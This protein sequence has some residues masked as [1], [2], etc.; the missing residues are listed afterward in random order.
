MKDEWVIHLIM[1]N[2][3][4]QM[5]KVAMELLATRQPKILDMRKRV[6]ELETSIWYTGA[7]G[8]NY[9]KV[10]PVQRDKYCSTCDSRKHEM[11]DC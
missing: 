9:S 8:K 5:T 7:S 3:D 1:E 10:A 11:R 4:Q 6:K 2:A